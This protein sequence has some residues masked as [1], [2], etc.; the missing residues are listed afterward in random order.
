MESRWLIAGALAP[1][2]ALVITVPVRAAT[3]QS[4]W[5]DAEANQLVFT[6]D[7]GVQPTAQMLSNPTRIVVDLPDT[8][9]G[10]NNTR[11]AVG[12]A[13]REVRAGQFDSRTARLVIELSEGYAVA[14]QEVRVQGVR[15]NQWVV[16][17]PTPSSTGAAPAGA[18]PTPSASAN[19]VQ[20]HTG[21]EA[22]ATLTGVV[23][24][25]DGFLIRVRGESPTPSV[26]ITGEG[27][28]D[29]MAVID[30]PNTVVSES[31]R[32]EDLPNYRY[33]ILTWDITQQDT[34]PPS[35][36]IALK[37]GP[38]SPDWR[39][40]RNNSGVVVL[41]PSGV[42]IS[43]VQD[44]PPPPQA[45]PAAPAAAQAPP[46]AA[47]PAPATPTPATPPL[48]E[49]APPPSGPVTM[50]QVPNGRVV[51]AID[52]GHGGRDP[53]AVGISGLQEKQVVNPI[54]LQVAEI[55]ESQGITV[56]MTRRDDRTLDLQTR[57]RIANQANA[58]LFVSIH[59]NAI[60]MSRP[61]V[62]GVETYFAS[63]SGRRLATAL[64]SSMLAATGMNDR[65]VKQ[66]RFY[67]LRHTTMPAALVE[68][69]FVTGAQDAPRLADPAWRSTMAQAIARG[70]LQYIQQGL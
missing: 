39:A 13:V 2:S 28:E 7:S 31:L 9:L 50:P 15:P 49:P 1:I 5:F 54:S 42:P 17:L 44:E 25:G 33:S 35:T 18:I 60:S 64:Q 19:R 66:A 3:L 12:G 27:L 61:D 20:G 24:T 4:W 69:G 26:Q 10:G 14:P 43:S 8:R 65:G 16:Q 11:Q 51:V 34:N 58:H 29:R 63:E 23:T 37:L 52:P 57:T 70:I 6:T 59:A 68:V 21:A 48:A 41:P 22:A 56:V 30:L 45:A 62:N 36:R 40:L 47:T 38:T 32:P 46:T 53:G 67:V 55:L